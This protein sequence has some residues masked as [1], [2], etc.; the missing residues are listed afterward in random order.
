ME[1]RNFTQPDDYSSFVLPELLGT[2]VPPPKRTVLDLGPASG[3]NVEQVAA[4]AKHCCK[5]YIANFF[6]D[7]S[8]AGPGARRNAAA[9]SAVCERLLDFPGETRFDLIF[10]WDLFNYLDLSEVEI[11]ARKLGR[12]SK[13]GTRLM[14]MVSIYQKIPDR[15]FRFSIRGGD[16]LRYETV[17]RGLRDCPRHKEVD[18]VRRMGG[19]QVE[20]AMLLRNGVQ[21]YS[22]V[23]E[24][25][26]TTAA[27]A[28]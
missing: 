10:A 5:L 17:S 22:F 2:L 1:E 28:S 3:D 20:R 13:P 27:V 21:E 8:E 7:L 11:L 4:Y 14:A 19:F 15:P 26:A 18:L 24:P 6:E 9:F 25:A 23:L 12:Y 16:S